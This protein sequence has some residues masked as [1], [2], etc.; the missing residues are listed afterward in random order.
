M[1]SV[2]EVTNYTEILEEEVDES[3]VI[4]VSGVSRTLGNKNE[5]VHGAPDILVSSSVHADFVNMT[6]RCLIKNSQRRLP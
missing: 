4:D 2:C 3:T 5:R 6:R 1:G